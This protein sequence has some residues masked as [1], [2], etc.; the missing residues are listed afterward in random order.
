MEILAIGNLAL[1]V[2]QVFILSISLGLLVRL[3]R[4]TEALERKIG[5]K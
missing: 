2:I 5:R 1:L 4:M 3:I